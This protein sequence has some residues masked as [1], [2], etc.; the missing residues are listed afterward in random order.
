MSTSAKHVAEAFIDELLRHDWESA[1]SMLSE[2]ATIFI[3]GRNV[4]SGTFTSP[5]HYRQTQ[6]WI[7]REHDA[8]IDVTGCSALLIDGETAVALVQERAHRDHQMIEYRR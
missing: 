4:L 8:G 5:S 7:F 6:S 3:S 2:T 1:W